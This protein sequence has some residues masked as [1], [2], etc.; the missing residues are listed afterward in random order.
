MASLA[1]P[2]LGESLSAYEGAPY[3]YGLTGYGVDTPAY[4]AGTFLPATQCRAGCDS[5]Q[6]KV[7]ELSKG[8]FSGT[9][10]ATSPQIL[11]G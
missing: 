10:I 9:F 5:E 7:R 11:F 3:N 2:P 4:E 1:R 8:S 6:H